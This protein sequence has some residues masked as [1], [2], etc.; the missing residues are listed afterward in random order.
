MKDKILPMLLFSVGAFLFYSCNT[1]TNT[2][3]SDLG[4]TTVAAAHAPADS[5]PAPAVVVTG[6]PRPLW[7]E[8]PHEAF[9]GS[10]TL[11][12]HFRNYKLFALDSL[13]MQSLLA[14]APKEK[15][16]TD[17]LKL[18][19]ELPKPDGGFMK[20]R[21]YRTTVMEP[22]LEAA[23]PLLKTYG[24]QGV[25]DRTAH[26]RLDF[27]QNGFHAYVSGQ[28]GEWFIQPPAR[29]I[30]HQYLLC[31]FKRDALSPNRKPFELP[32]SPKK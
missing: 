29:E 4:D 31:F 26:V 3:R 1:G 23:Y 28:G 21:I 32:R 6:K 27:N 14:K 22:A 18:I 25:D 12:T 15:Q 9:K 24:G 8:L 16:N 13:K 20:F 30:T 19:I 2:N 10:D 17:S 7:T 11:K 5:L